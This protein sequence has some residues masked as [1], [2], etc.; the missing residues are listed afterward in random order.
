[1]A[2]KNLTIHIL[3]E[4]GSKLTITALVLLLLTLNILPFSS[5][6]IINLE[7]VFVGSFS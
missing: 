2:G 6:S 3:R 7:H 5:V 1:M 4:I